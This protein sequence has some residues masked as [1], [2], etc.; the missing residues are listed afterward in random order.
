MSTETSKAQDEVS[1]S[2]TANKGSTERVGAGGVYTVT[3]VGADG[4]EK[5]SD[6]FHNLVV[7]EGLQDMNSKYFKGSGY[8]AG[9]Y[10]GLVQGPGSGTTYAAGDTLA[11]HAGWTELV[12]GTAYTG[13]RIAV[14]FN[15]ASP[16]L[17]DPS[18]V[19][20]S[21]APSVF[22]MLVNSTVV[23]GAFLTTA[24]TGTSGV[25]FSAGDFTGGDKTVDAG[26]TLNV[27]YTFSLD[28][29]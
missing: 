13:N 4:V 1:A 22:P 29:A 14:V 21:T 20:N 3:C 16:S 24:A 27:T 11:S 18:V 26:D 2:L 12:P 7:N 9:W 23:A 5:W 28:A 25:L 15:T 6:T 17:A 10:L 8:T 19:T